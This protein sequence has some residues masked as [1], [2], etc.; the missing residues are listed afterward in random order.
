MSRISKEKAKEVSELM[1][2]E[3]SD[4]VKLAKKELNDAMLIVM[5][6]RTPKQVQECFEKYPEYFD[7]VSTVYV[8]DN[9]F[10]GQNI[11]TSER[12]ISKSGK[13]S[14]TIQITEAEAKMIL[15]LLNKYEDKEKEYK[16]IQRSIENTLYSLKTYAAIGKNFPE[17]VPHLPSP[18]STSLTIP[19]EDIRKKLNSFK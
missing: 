13:Y 12:F 1:T 9:G 16:D 6:K 19:I 4:T 18:T 10:T 15:P 8:Q 14:T 11:N 2:K 5:Q 17:A 3:I 7:T